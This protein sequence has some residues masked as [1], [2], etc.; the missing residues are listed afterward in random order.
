MLIW[1][2]LISVLD[3]DYIFILR[4]IIYGPPNKINDKP[5]FIKSVH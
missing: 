2:I 1:F 4:K 3:E 5:Q